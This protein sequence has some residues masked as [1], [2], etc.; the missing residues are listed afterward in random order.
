M[1]QTLNEKHNHLTWQVYDVRLSTRRIIAVC[2][3]TYVINQEWFPLHVCANLFHDF[4]FHFFLCNPELTQKSPRGIQG[5]NCVLWVLM[6]PS[7]VGAHLGTTWV[8]ARMGPTGVSA[9]LSRH[10]PGSHLGRRPPES[11]LNQRLL[12]FT[13]VRGPTWIDLHGLPPGQR[14]PVSHL[15]RRPRRSHV[16]RRPQGSP[17]WLAP[18]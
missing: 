16:S 4:A 15:G 9:H 1:Q 10:P 3:Y 2:V 12:G 11:H 7:S 8:S 13:W 14:P 18:C 17:L 5:N 6:V